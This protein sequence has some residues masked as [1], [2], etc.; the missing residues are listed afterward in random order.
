M[1]SRLV[2]KVRSGLETV[3]LKTPKKHAHS[4]IGE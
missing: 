4:K 2:S 3:G 1:Q